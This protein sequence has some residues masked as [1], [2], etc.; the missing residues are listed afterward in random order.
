MRDHPIVY[1]LLPSILPFVKSKEW[2]EMFGPKLRRTTL[3]QLA[4]S[5][6]EWGYTYVVSACEMQRP[7]A[8]RSAGLQEADEVT[9]LENA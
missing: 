7:R 6:H 8:G 3:L 5:N 2:A 4:S 9:T 1:P